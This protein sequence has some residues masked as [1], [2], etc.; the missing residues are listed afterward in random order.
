MPGTVRST[1]AALTLIA[2]ALLAVVLTAMVLFALAPWATRKPPRVSASTAGAVAA[3]M[4]RRRDV[5]NM[6]SAGPSVLMVIARG[7]RTLLVARK[8]R[9]GCR[10]N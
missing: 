5:R 1:S 10:E 9:K 7:T 8:A 3:T 4:R 2:M 6:D